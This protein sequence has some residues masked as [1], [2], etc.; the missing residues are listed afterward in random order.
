M[1]LTHVRLLVDKFDE[2]FR[3]YRDVLGFAVEWGAEGSD[4]ASFR[5]A[6][7]EAMVALFSR[8]AMDDLLGGTQPS[9]A[10]PRDDR[11]ML[12]FDAADLDSTVTALKARGA[13]FVLDITERPDW[14][15]RAAHL[16]DPEGNLIELN[17]P[18]PQEQ[19]SDELA[20]EAEQYTVTGEAEDARGRTDIGETHTLQ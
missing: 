6:H 3:F 12:V 13:A 2:C 15:I 19:W 9:P 8:Q 11:T 17:S 16:R 5:T 1:K 18:L 10:L 20:D 7:G 4:Y 14:G